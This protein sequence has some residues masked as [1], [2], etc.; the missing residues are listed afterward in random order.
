MLRLSRALVL[1]FAF[2]LSAKVALPW[3]QG[4]SFVATLGMV[5]TLWQWPS[6]PSKLRFDT[7][8][9]WFVDLDES[10]CHLLGRWL[11]PF[12]LLLKTTHPHLRYWWIAQDAC[13][14]GT[15]R[16]MALWSRH[17]IKRCKGAK[18]VGREDSSVSG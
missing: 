2:G 12:G 15:Y 4:L 3:W 5:L 7:K 10:P 17:Q 14:E 18:I 9:G 8:R 6:V 16:F 11:T 1:I 13:D